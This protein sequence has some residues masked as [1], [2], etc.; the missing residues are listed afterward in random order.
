M[1]SNGSAGQAARTS[2]PVPVSCTTQPAQCV[3]KNINQKADIYIL[4]CLSSP[5][6]SN[7]YSG[8]NVIMSHQRDGEEGPVAVGWEIR[9]PLTCDI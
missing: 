1:I 9:Q 5:L 3:G 6:S 8:Q 2:G 7:Q 4:F